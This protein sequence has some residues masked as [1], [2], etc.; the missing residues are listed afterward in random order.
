MMRKAVE[1]LL[2]S[3]VVVMVLGGYF[4]FVG[5]I[6]F[7]VNQT[8]TQKSGT[9]DVSG[10]G[11]KSIAPDEAIIDLGIRKQAKTVKEAQKMAN[12]SLDSLVKELG[13]L[14]ISEKDTKTVNYS[15]NPEYDPENYQ[16]INGYIVNVNVEVK[17]KEGNFEKL[18]QV[19][20]LSGQLGLEQMGGLRFELSDELEKKTQEEARSLAVSEAKDKAES[21][22]KLAGV[23]LGKIVN[24]SESFG[25]RPVP[26]FAR[27][28]VMMAK[29]S[30]VA[31]QVNPG[32]TDLEVVVTLSY[33]TL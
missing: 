13:K 12:I 4:K 30:G 27:A 8:S 28:E 20:D 32:T 10:T 2:V 3:L 14:G 9:F 11:T 26:M 24:V 1:T 15:V 19:M 23:K 18:E 7:N 16:K 22:A 29:D 5:G 17:I 25:G 31:S 6:P 21:L 33:E